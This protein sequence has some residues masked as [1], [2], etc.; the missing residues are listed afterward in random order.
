[1]NRCVFSEGCW[2][3]EASRACAAVSVP[4]MSFFSLPHPLLTPSAEYELPDFELH[5]ESQVLSGALRSC[6]PARRS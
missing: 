3:R 4:G 5:D 2:P 1:M 6:V